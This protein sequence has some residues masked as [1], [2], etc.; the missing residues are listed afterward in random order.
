MTYDPRLAVVGLLPGNRRGARARFRSKITKTVGPRAQPRGIN[1]NFNNSD[2]LRWLER[3]RRWGTRITLR[4]NIVAA[5]H[6][7]VIRHTYSVL[8]RDIRRFARFY[9][10]VI[11]FSPRCKAFVF[12]SCDVAM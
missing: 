9:S 2:R 1:I 6:E 10:R 7:S 11:G 12:K 5:G 3:T 8:K 4:L